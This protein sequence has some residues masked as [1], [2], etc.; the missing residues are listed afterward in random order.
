MIGTVLPEKTAIFTARPKTV[1]L[2]KMKTTSVII[3]TIIFVVYNLIKKIPFLINKVLSRNFHQKEGQET[4]LSVNSNIIKS[5]A[6]E[7]GFQYRPI[8]HEFYEVFKDDIRF[9]FRSSNFEFEN[10]VAY[11]ICGNKEVTNKILHDNGFP[12]PNYKC[13]SITDVQIALEFFCK[14][15]CLYVVKPVHGSKGDGVV[16]HIQTRANLLLAMAYAFSHSKGRIMLE[17]FFDGTNFRFTVLDGEVLSVVERIPAYVVGDGS[18]PINKLIDA[19]NMKIGRTDYTQLWKIK[20][21]WKTRQYLK[22]QGLALSSVP[23]ANSI[24][25]VSGTC[26]RAEGGE[27]QN[28]KHLVHSSYM[29]IAIEATN[30]VHSRFCGVD[31]IAKNIGK[32]ASKENFIINELNTTPALDLIYNSNT[33]ETSESIKKI[34]NRARD[35]S[36]NY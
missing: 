11:Q 24:V 2:T 12:V 27:I 19:K 26:N 25:Q 6:Q 8:G 33:H 28:I 36:E 17:Q 32:G 29:E 16:T 10:L 20:K 23:T 22:S 13:L 14:D 31:I 21:S 7:L 1:E 34:I 30:S 4:A 15:K 18:T 35:F 5:A 9:Y 3:L